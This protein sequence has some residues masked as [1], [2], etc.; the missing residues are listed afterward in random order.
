MSGLICTICFVIYQ[1]AN[2]LHYITSF[3]NILFEYVE[4]TFIIGDINAYFEKRSFEKLL[5][6]FKIYKNIR[7]T[8]KENSFYLL[9]PW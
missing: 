9:M 7:L 1:K 4:N 3:E 8:L 6:K 2:Y 5:Q